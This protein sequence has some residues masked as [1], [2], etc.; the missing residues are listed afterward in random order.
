MSEEYWD[1]EKSVRKEIVSTSNFDNIKTA[2]LVSALI[3][4]NYDLYEFIVSKIDSRLNKYQ[5]ISR[6]DNEDELID[7]TLKLIEK[8]KPEW[9]R[10]DDNQNQETLDK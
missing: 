9:F 5:Y 4:V 1:L 8:R 2:L 3:E 7:E 10:T 6:I